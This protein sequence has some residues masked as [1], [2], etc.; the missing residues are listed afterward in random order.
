M[1]LYVQR[2]IDERAEKAKAENNPF[3]ENVRQAGD[4]I[5]IMVGKTRNHADKNASKYAVLQS[6]GSALRA[7]STVTKAQ[8][9]QFT[10]CNGNVL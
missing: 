4:E 10:D 7:L 3:P 5:L 2:S 8:Y 6:V 1:A 9:P